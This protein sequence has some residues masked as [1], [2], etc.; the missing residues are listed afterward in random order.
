MAGRKKEADTP[1]DLPAAAQPAIFVTELAL[2]ELIRSWGIE[3]EAMIGH[4]IGEFTAAHLAGVI[5][6]PD[7]LEVVAA[8]ARLIQTQVGTGAMLAVP[9]T[10]EELKPLLPDGVSLGAIN[11]PRLCIASGEESAVTDLMA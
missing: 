2:A 3:P 6:L 7:A 11:A 4:S 5:S 10:E 8:R 9:L 1:G